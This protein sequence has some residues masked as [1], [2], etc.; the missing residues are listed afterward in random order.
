MINNIFSLI[1]YIF[2][3]AASIAAYALLIV[4][5]YP[6]L[7]VK[8]SA[9]GRGDRGI[10][11]YVFEGGRS[12][13]FEPEL[14]IRKYIKQYALSCL[15]DDKYIKCRI[16]DKVKYIS[17]DVLAYDNRDS[18]IDIIEISERVATAGYTRSV[19]L[20]VQTSYVSV[21]L[22]YADKNY[23][24]SSRVIGYDKKG[25][26]T[27]AVLTFVTTVIQSVL[28]LGLA[29]KIWDCFF[30]PQTFVDGASI[31]IRSV[32]IGALAS[33]LILLAYYRRSVKE[34]NR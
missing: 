3:V 2:M 26:L 18:L 27:Y 19:L 32:V 25:L 28:M 4:T 22:R 30:K 5:V 1:G 17:F 9:S 6:R 7:C 24:D 13:V 23:S 20:P 15:D 29:D 21:I 16:G 31:V 10:K 8:W 11:K 14:K 33:V 34:I 12:V